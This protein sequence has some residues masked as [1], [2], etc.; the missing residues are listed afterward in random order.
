M[1]I[2]FD[3]QIHW[4]WFKHQDLRHMNAEKGVNLGSNIYSESYFIILMKYLLVTS[5][6]YTYKVKIVCE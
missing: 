2:K 3:L 1:I 6:K 4:S 5:N